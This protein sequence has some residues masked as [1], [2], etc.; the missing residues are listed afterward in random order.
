MRF[1][2]PYVTGAYAPE[3]LDDS[4]Q[5]R[6][7]GEQSRFVVPAP[8]RRLLLRLWAHHPDIERRPVRVLISTRC[9]V[10]FDRILASN[11]PVSVGVTLPAG[12]D[13]FDA[14]ITVS[15]TWSPADS[16]G[17]DTR[18]LGVAVQ[19]DFAEDGEIAPPTDH[20]AEWRHCG[21][22]LL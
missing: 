3:R 10:L 20:E 1:R 9:D 18:R 5:F 2:R 6:W 16:G 4:R 22:G 15:R 14:S 12:T 11:D 13:T 7:T 17:T 8:S 21:A 19:L